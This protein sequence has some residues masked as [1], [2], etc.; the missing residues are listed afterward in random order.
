MRIPK[1]Y[2]YL[3]P[4]APRDKTTGKIILRAL[5]NMTEKEAYTFAW[6]CMDSPHHLDKSSRIKKSDIEI[7]LVQDDG[8]LYLDADIY[9][10]IGVTCG[11]FEGSVVLRK[12]GSICV[13][14]HD[15]KKQEPID[16]MAHK[17]LWLINKNFDLFGLIKG[18]RAIDATENNV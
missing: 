9:V 14:D 11:C 18:N 1:D 15:G 17:I 16:D 13:E 8:G 3:Y 6:M 12:D 10:Y 7:E 5:T 4:N 2:S